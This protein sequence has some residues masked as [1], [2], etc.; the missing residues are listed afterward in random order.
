MTPPA[1]RAYLI[2]QKPTLE[3]L[4]ELMRN[5][6]DS[7]PN[8]LIDDPELSIL[9]LMYYKEAGGQGLIDMTTNGSQITLAHDICTLIQFHHYG[10]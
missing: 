9:E 4:G 10:G 7:R 3:N 6:Y 1:D 2:D 8:L 5:P